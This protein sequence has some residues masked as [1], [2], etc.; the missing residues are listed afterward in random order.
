MTLQQH[1]EQELKA[2][3]INGVEMTEEQAA[4]AEALSVYCGN[5]LGEGEPDDVSRLI[6]IL[7]SLLSA[8]LQKQPDRIIQ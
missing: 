8:A 3:Q 6:Y 1:I 4:Q 2:M 5:L 7:G